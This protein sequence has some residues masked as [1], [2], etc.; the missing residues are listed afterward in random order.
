MARCFNVG[1][2]WCARTG[3]PRWESLPSR[4]CRRTLPF[5][6]VVS[7]WLLQRTV[8]TEKGK[9]LTSA[10][11]LFDLDDIITHGETAFLTERSQSCDVIQ[12]HRNSSSE[13]RCPTKAIVV[14]GLKCICDWLANSF[15]PSCPMVLL[16]LKKSD[17]FGVLDPVKVLQHEPSQKRMYA[18][19]RSWEEDAMAFKDFLDNERVLRVFY[20]Q[21]PPIFHHK[22]DIVPLGPSRQ[23]MHVYPLFRQ[24]F[25][26]RS[27]HAATLYYVNHSPIPH[28]QKVFAKTNKNFGGQLNNE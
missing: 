18:G 26:T 10:N 19:C 14:D 17:N 15:E 21:T 20:K 9:G 11:G 16:L 1:V 3:Y 5:L 27:R 4:M 6:L 8:K 22:I 7:I 12:K 24:E 13:H 23:F 28:R 25:M 2:F